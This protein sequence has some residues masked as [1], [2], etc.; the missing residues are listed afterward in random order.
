MN[1]GVFRR[2]SSVVVVTYFYGYPVSRP[3]ST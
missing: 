2:Q 3:A 1:D